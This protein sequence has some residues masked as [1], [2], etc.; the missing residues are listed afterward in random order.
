MVQPR[1]VESIRYYGNTVKKFNTKVI[2]QSICSDETLRKVKIML[3]GVV[4][5]GTAR[6]LS[7]ENFKI[8]GKTGTA[9]IANDK[10]GYK[11]GTKI[12]YQASFVGYF[13]AEKP[14][15]SCIVVVNSPTEKV[16]YGNLVAGPVFREISRKV[17]AT[18]LDLHQEMVP[19]EGYR[20][21]ETT[22]GRHFVCSFAE[23]RTKLA[24]HCALQ[25]CC[26]FSSSHENGVSG[27]S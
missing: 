15:Y 26:R 8:A 17:Y 16:Y 2:D 20:A 12:S 1:I 27:Q 4:E 22:H 14:K 9:Q 5:N 19:A 21:D 6:N 25:N 7:N 11:V 23:W 10:Y 13:P 3:E 18:S 24:K